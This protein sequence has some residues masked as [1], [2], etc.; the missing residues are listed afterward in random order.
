[1]VRTYFFSTFFSLFIFLLC[2]VAP[3]LSSIFHVAIYL[4]LSFISVSPIVFLLHSS[5]IPFLFTIHSFHLAALNQALY[6][7][8]IILISYYLR[9]Y[10]FCLLAIIRIFPRS[11]SYLFP[12]FLF[13]LSPSPSLDHPISSVSLNF[14]AF[15]VDRHYFYLCFLITNLLTL[16]HSYLS[17]PFPFLISSPVKS[18]C[19]ELF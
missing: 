15:L 12:S 9:V 4:V 19:F 7:H 16:L 1:M 5:S 11:I 6:F 10:Q 13:L 2:Y 17:F 8:I 18:G 14:F 3:C